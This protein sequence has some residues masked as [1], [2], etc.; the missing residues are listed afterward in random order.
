MLLLCWLA[1]FC[2]NSSMPRWW[3]V[4]SQ[5]EL[6]AM[7]YRLLPTWWQQPGKL[8]TMSNWYNYWWGPLR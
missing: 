3:G 7:W 8:Y 4:S 2:A 6:W 1:A 5:W